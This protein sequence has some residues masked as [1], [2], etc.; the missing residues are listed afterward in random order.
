MR[1]PTVDHVRSC[2]RFRQDED[3]L[4]VWVDGG[5]DSQ[6]VRVAYWQTIVDEARRLGCRRLLVM[7]RKKGR[8]ATPLELAQLALM[9]RA[10]AVHFD[11]IAVVEPSAEFI[12]VL[13]HGEIAARMV[14]INLR[15]FG[16][17][18]SAEHWLRYGW[19]A[20]DDDAD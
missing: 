7:D 11:A 10:E 5:A 9:F 6:Q 16:E 14:G 15:V 18:R 12:P 1:R 13:E 8:S 2:L 17:A 19:K 4:R 3:L 20:P